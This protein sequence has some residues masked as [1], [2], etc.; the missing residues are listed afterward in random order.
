MANIKQ[1]Q[2]KG[3]DMKDFSV[4]YL[5]SKKLLEEYYTACINQD[6]DLARQIANDLVEAVLK[7]EDI[8]HDA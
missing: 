7:L 1:Q 8:T 5:T 3:H 6:K 4:P 2:T